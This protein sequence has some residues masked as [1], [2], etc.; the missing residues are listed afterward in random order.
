MGVAGSIAQSRSCKM[1]EH[2]GV[3]RISLHFTL[4]L[5]FLVLGSVYSA[6]KREAS[7]VKKD[8]TMDDYLE[9]H[10][11]KVEPP[12][13]NASPLELCILLTIEICM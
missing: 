9:D 6:D 2:S 11:A 1:A 8:I 5:L 12:S 3:C 7:A 10:N 4:V 13:K